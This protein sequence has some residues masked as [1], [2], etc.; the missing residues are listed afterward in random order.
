MALANHPSL[1]AAAAGVKS[2]NA[3]TSEARGALLPRVSYTEQ[4]Q[5]S[6]NPVY[7]FGS[8]LNQRQ[9]EAQ[10]FQLGFL[11]HP[12]FV[13]H[14]QSLVTAEQTLYDHGLRKS[15]IK[16]AELGEKVSS[17]EARGSELSVIAGALQ[18][19]YAAVLA[20]AN[21]EVAAAAVR[22]AEADLKRAEDRRGAGLT[23]DADVLSIRVH[24]AAV[25][26]QQIARQGDLELARAAL[27]AAMGV[28]LETPFTLVTSLAA[29]KVESEG[30]LGAIETDAAANRPETRLARLQTEIRGEQTKAA[31]SALAPEAFV[32]GGFEAD[33]GNFVNGGANWMVSAGLRWNLFDG[34]SKQA[35]IAQAN[36]ESEKARALE[37]QAV[38]SAQLSARSAW[39]AL[40]TANEQIEVAKAA[41]DLAQESLRVIRNR[42]EAGLTE[43]TELL[44]AEN[45]LL[46]AQTRALEALANQR[47]AA[48]ALE[49]ARGRLTQDSDVVNH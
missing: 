16:A 21:V 45:A 31:R 47:V 6:N 11:N 24:V 44:R 27:N 23:T 35:R 17:E 46:D 29:A 32:R 3:R 43:V 14:F 33:R 8:L 7:V 2:A 9:F 4:W 26:E 34:F 22:S 36:H 48:V 37:Q 1:Q 15:H 39:L 19:Y 20:Q 25:R 10:N 40:R 18:A 28:P 30:G 5:R 38:T 12:P 49:A 41:A 13:D 42:Y